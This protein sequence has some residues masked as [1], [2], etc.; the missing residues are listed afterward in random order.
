[1]AR[2]SWSGQLRQHRSSGASHCSKEMEGKVLAEA[3]QDG[4]EEGMKGFPFQSFHSR[5]GRAGGHVGGV[6]DRDA[7]GA[8]PV[9]YEGK[10]QIQAP[11]HKQKKAAGSS[12]RHRDGAGQRRHG[13]ALELG[14]AAGCGAE[15]ES[16]GTASAFAPHHHSR[17]DTRQGHAYTG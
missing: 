7:R 8:S 6:T 10:I 2:C 14:N 13:L 9:Q 12:R 5:K 1:M 17:G 4:G 15:L 11:K 16:R 3:G